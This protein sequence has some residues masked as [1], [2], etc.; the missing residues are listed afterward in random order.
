MVNDDLF[1][2]QDELPAEERRRTEESHANGQV[3]ELQP[4]R[5]RC[6]Q[7]GGPNPYEGNQSLI[8]ETIRKPTKEDEELEKKMVE[9]E[10][11]HKLALAKA[12]KEQMLKLEEEKKKN[13]PVSEIER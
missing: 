4:P 13:L 8:Q 5:T 6:A 12:K 2:H 1:R 3:K 7:A 10:K 11:E 9:E